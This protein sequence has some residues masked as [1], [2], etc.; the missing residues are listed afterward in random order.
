MRKTRKKPINVLAK[1][2]IT[3]DMRI[4]AKVVYGMPIRAFTFFRGVRGECNA[5]KIP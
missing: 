5:P 1:H 4:K 3:Y 2:D